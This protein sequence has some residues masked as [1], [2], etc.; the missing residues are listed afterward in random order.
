MIVVT[1]EARTAAKIGAA[2]TGK[3]MSEFASQAIQAAAIAKQ[4]AHKP[5][6]QGKR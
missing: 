1:K 6:R 4:K 5:E 2:L 3:S